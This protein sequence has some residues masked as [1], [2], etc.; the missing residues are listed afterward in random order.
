MLGVVVYMVSGSGRLDC[1][2]DTNDIRT[3]S[4]CHNWSARLAQHFGSSP[5][6]VNI[7]KRFFTEKR[8]HICIVDQSDNLKKADDWREIINKYNYLLILSCKFDGVQNLFSND[9]INIFIRINTYNYFSDNYHIERK[10]IRIISDK[11]T[12][13]QKPPVDKS[14]III[15][16]LLLS[17]LFW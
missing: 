6:F 9:L 13:Y 2:G 5:R 17:L 11:Y 15:L 3:T 12:K 8:K 16:L 14:L 1:F 10:K 4:F 7:L